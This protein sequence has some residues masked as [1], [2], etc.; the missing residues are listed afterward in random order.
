M[1]G[2]LLIKT[3][4]SVAGNKQY[5]LVC[6]VIQCPIFYMGKD[7]DAKIH[8]RFCN[9]TVNGVKGWGISEWDYR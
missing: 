6:E 3:V 1:Q 7:W 2:N 8:E 4:C 9:Y 5:H